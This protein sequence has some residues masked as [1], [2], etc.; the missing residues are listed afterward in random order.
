MTNQ[1][2]SSITPATINSLADGPLIG[3]YRENIII[4]TDTQS[5]LFHYTTTISNINNIQMY[6]IN[7]IA[8][9]EHTATYT[10]HSS[11]QWLLGISQ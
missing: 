3:S 2:S 1:P 10:P 7:F 8:I 11:N 6:N 4:Y 5:S 9:I